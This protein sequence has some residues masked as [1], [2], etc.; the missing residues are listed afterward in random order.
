[1]TIVFQYRITDWMLL[2]RQRRHRGHCNVIPSRKCL[3]FQIFSGNLV[4]LKCIATHFLYWSASYQAKWGLHSCKNSEIRHLPLYCV[5][6]FVELTFLFRYQVPL[7][8][9]LSYLFAFYFPQGFHKS[10][11]LHMYVYMYNFSLP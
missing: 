9:L 7:L 6:Y 5:F 8:E 10:A 2:V 4:K 1:M 11:F 3:D